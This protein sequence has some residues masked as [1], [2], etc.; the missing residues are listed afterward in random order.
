MLVTTFQVPPHTKTT[1][2]IAWR[3]PV[4][5]S[6]GNNRAL[7]HQTCSGAAVQKHC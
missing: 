7:E 2:T 6:A 5:I 4:I 3:V 1:A